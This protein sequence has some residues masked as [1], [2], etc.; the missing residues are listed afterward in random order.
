M[1]IAVGAT[2][3]IKT[4]AVQ[5]TV[6]TLFPE[7]QVLLLNMGLEEQVFGFDQLAQGANAK[8]QQALELQK[9]YVGIGIENGLVKI[10][11]SGWFD[12]VCVAALT[13]DAKTSIGFGA[14][15]FIPDWVVSEIKEKKAKLSEIIGRLSAGS[16]Q[17][18]VGY[19]SNHM[20]TRE[21]ELKR[22]VLGAL[23]KIVNPD[24][25]HL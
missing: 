19:F 12:F 20:L 11:A 22:T 25:Y 17:D 9:A 16:D 4:E 5:E 1:I 8:A 23:S 21:D 6:K 3:E 15:F 14:G 24:R 7:S 10:E 13:A 18:P 2:S